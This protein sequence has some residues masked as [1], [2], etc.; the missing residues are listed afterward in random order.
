MLRRPFVLAPF[1]LALA[2]L[3]PG[4]WGGCGWSNFRSAHPARVNIEYVE[5]P[6]TVDAIEAPSVLPSDCGPDKSGWRCYDTFSALVLEERMAQMRRW[7][8]GVRKQ[9]VMEYR[10][11]DYRL[12]PPFRRGSF[13]TGDR[14]RLSALPNN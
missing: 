7:I 3:A 12:L 2:V 13:I 4:V 8:D 6:C 10:P 11:S 5:S 14:L 9:C 1:V